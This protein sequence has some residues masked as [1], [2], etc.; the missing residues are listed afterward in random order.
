MNLLLGVT[1]S[2]AAKLTP[3]LVD[4]LQRGGFQVKI[5]ATESSLFFW[6]RWEVQAPVHRNQDEWLAKY[7]PRSPIL[8][9]E[10]RNW[11]DIMV[12][13]PLS[14]NTLAKMAAGITDNLL[15]SVVRAWDRSKLMIVAPAMNTHMWE[16]PATEEHLATLVRWYPKIK[17][18]D[19]IV[20]VL[21]CGDVGMGAMAEVPGIVDEVKKCAR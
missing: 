8:H 9:I 7:E 11:A 13:A 2:V 4:E 10:L 21:E 15:T 17:I 5:V 19:P 20:K 6:D 1:G 3:K 12:I 18:I 14:A 16:H